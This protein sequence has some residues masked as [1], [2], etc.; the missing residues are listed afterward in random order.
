MKKVNNY[1]NTFGFWM[2]TQAIPNSKNKKRIANKKYRNFVK[3][4]LMK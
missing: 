3:E 4:I 2:F 1:Y